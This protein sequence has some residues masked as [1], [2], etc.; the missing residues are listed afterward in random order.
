MQINLKQST[1]TNIQKEALGVTK[2]WYSFCFLLISKFA[3][4][5]GGASKRLSPAE[6]KQAYRA[7]AADSVREQGDEGNYGYLINLLV[8]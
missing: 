1:D 7:D 5:R 6:K 4:G 2:S 8:C 3:R